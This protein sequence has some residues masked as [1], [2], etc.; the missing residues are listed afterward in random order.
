MTYGSVAWSMMAISEP[1][2][3]RT[4]SL[5]EP[6]PVGPAEVAERLG[7]AVATVR[8]WRHDR[9]LPP[10]RWQISRGPVWDWRDIEI[11]AVAA[12]RLPSNPSAP[13]SPLPDED[14]PQLLSS[15]E[16]ARR[17]GTTGGAVRARARRGQIPPPRWHI[18][19]RA[20]WDSRDIDA[21]L[22]RADD[23]TAL[24]SPR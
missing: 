24:R 8:V 17:I 19:G 5:C 6:Q 1:P 22:R 2:L 10:A 20:V 15:D 11:W 9:V 23:P 14:L 18:A 13:T 21:W 7:V 4:E 3:A 12:G 16:V